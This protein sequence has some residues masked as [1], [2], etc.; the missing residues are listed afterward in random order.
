MLY[1]DPVGSI[2]RMH[3]EGFRKVPYPVFMTCFNKLVKDPSEVEPL[4]PSEELKE[5]FRAVCLA[6]DAGI[7]DPLGRGQDRRKEFQ[8]R[9]Y[10]VWKQGLREAEFR[11]YQEILD[12]KL[13]ERL[14]RERREQQQRDADE[15]RKR[16]E[17]PQAARSQD[18]K[19]ALFE[20][21]TQA[22]LKEAEA[23]EGGG[24]EITAV[25]IG[26]APEHH[27]V[28]E[29]AVAISEGKIPI[30]Y[31]PPEGKKAYAYYLY[32]KQKV[33]V[34]LVKTRHTH[35]VALRYP[36]GFAKRVGS[37]LIVKRLMEEGGYTERKPF[38]YF[39]EQYFFTLR[40]RI[41]TTS[42]NI[43]QQRHPE[44]TV[45]GLAQAVRALHAELV[46]IFNVLEATWP[47][48]AEEA[49]G[50]GASE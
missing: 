10:P 17:E 24:E 39:K 49:E 42:T 20:R 50:E 7:A 12:G 26:P 18:E 38:S 3:R 15:A 8:E 5:Y 29:L 44:F 11:V 41:G 40:L 46:R 43:V 21:L 23:E 13:R 16:R 1:T 31:S 32:L 25:V 4:P 28:E 33:A 19:H 30:W 36:R 47:E 2:T 22:A 45:Q 35:C 27:S 37:G 6:L 34:Q 48:E 14:D 9:I